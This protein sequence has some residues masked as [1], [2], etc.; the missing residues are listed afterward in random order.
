MDCDAV[1][2][3]IGQVHMS[4]ISMLAYNDENALSCVITLAYYNAV[5]DYI[6]RREMPAGRDMQMLYL[7]QEDI[8]INRR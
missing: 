4:N 8:Q 1:A 2:K 7:F 6:M 5:K 3:G